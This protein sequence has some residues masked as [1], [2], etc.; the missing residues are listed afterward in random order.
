MRRLV[1]GLFSCLAVVTA[2]GPNKPAVHPVA[3]MAPVDLSCPSV[4]YTAVDD[5]RI[6]ATGCGRHAD[7]VR[8]CRVVR[9]NFFMFENDCSWVRR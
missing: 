3:T 7:Y 5:N 2:C 4:G 8:T 9:G 6:G 1:L